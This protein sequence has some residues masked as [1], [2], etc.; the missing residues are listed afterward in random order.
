VVDTEP[1][2]T[3]VGLDWN[4]L[5][6]MARFGE[7]WHHEPPHWRAADA[8]SIRATVR[9]GLWHVRAFWRERGVWPATTPV[10]EAGADVVDGSVSPDDQLCTGCGQDLRQGASELVEDQSGQVRAFCSELCRARS[11]YHDEFE[12][13]TDTP[14]AHQLWTGDP[15]GWHRA[16]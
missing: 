6:R 5:Y 15:D 11:S 3:I 9:R 12:P 4:G 1:E 8:C 14:D 16:F 2:A 7:Y 10:E 13:V